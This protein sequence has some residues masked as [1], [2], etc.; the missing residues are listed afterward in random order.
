MGSKESLNMGSSTNLISNLKSMLSGL[1]QQISG[2][3]SAIHTMN[4]A[5]SGVSA[6]GTQVAPGPVFSSAPGIVPH[7]AES[8]NKVAAGPTQSMSSPSNG[9]ANLTSY[10]QQNP[11]NGTLYTK[12]GG[13]SVGAGN[14][15]SGG[16]GG[17]GFGGNFV[18]AG[19]GTAGLASAITSMLGDTTIAGLNTILQGA[20]FVS[21]NLM[22]STSD[23]V[24]A[25]LLAQRSS[26]FTMKNAGQESV[27]GKTSPFESSVKLSNDLAKA[28]TVTSSLDALKG[29]TAAQSYGLTGPN[30][31][32]VMGGVANLSNLVPGA[33][34]EG[35]TRAVGAM[36]AGRSV[37]MLK[38]IGI[39]LRD[40][41]GNLTSPDKVID[42]LW[43]KICKDFN[44]SGQ[45][46]APTLNMV[47]IGLEPGN[48]LDSMLNT[49]FGGDPILKQMVA[50]GLIF[51]AQTGGATLQTVTG[52]KTDVK[53]AIM[54][55]GG[56]TTAALQGSAVNAAAGG[57]IAG[58]STTGYVEATGAILRGIQGI[59]DTITNNQTLE[60]KQILDTLLSGSNYSYTGI[61]YAAKDIVGKLTSLFES[62]EP[63][64]LKD[65][66]NLGGTGKAVGGPVSGNQPYLIGEQGPEIFVPS[67]SGNIIPN[68]QLTK[69]SGGGSATYNF[70]VNLPSANTPEVIAALKNMVAELNT[71]R[72]ISDS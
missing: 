4:G 31:N 43:T 26:F 10:I 69:G 21:N 24:E 23:I 59:V 34:I 7:P 65:L 62:N 32:E 29:M 46:G 9:G 41:A 56:T 42:Q 19:G 71:N 49:Y 39:Q 64:W 63:S 8:Q 37:N 38:G 13:G 54:N 28:G 50:N 60:T 6:G 5:S 45:S 22:P 66:L 2:L 51:K 58:Q 35:T 36:Q 67:T 52:E 30:F 12:S 20:N 3:G 15:N 57:V 68:N 53:T 27:S 55:A 47:R 25:N 44:R 40:E 16:G 18:A 1:T 72:K 48:S 70:T 33:G 61:P 11:N 14:N 17:G